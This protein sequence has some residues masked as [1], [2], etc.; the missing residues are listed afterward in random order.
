MFGFFLYQ[1]A[2]VWETEPDIYVAFIGPTK[3]E[4]E[5]KVKR[6]MGNVT[7][8]RFLGGQKNLQSA[9]GM[10]D[11]F[12]N[13]P[14]LGGGTGAILAMLERKPII[15]LAGCDVASSVGEDFFC[16]CVEKFPEKILRYRR[17]SVYYEKQSKAAKEK[18]KECVKTDEEHAQIL[19]GVLDLIE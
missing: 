9:I 4:F 17:D 15:T 8:I 1:I 5:E 13:P 11:I 10:M 3:V 18:S 12:V 16:E 6:E 7:H 2:R 14:R 19:Q